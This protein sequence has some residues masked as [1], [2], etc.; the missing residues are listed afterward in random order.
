MTNIID[1]GMLELLA[2]K[3]CHDL[4]SPI[5]AVN[6]GIELISD[7]GPDAG[8]EAMELIAFS[9]QQASA[10]LQAFRLAYGAGGADKNLKPEDAYKAIQ[11]IVGAE[12]KITQNWDPHGNLGPLTQQAGICKILVCAL[13]LAI[14]ALPKGGT[15]TV[16]LNGDHIVVRAEGR[17]AILREAAE[18]ALKGQIDPARLEPK[19]VHAAL[20][21]IMARAYQLA[22]SLERNETGFV[23]LGIK[24]TAS[25]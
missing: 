9:A 19:Y 10:K 18:Q 7:M 15:L 24:S 1:A 25:L 21:A 11:Q 4:I 5:G 3:I 13:L 22:I 17:D 6:N 14:E 12:K 20:S 23:E 8:P 2:S 16:A